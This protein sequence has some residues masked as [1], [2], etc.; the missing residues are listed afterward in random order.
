LL[1]A[2]EH[3]ESVLPTLSQ[4]IKNQFSGEIKVLENGLFPRIK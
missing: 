2:A 3:L 4:K 1:L